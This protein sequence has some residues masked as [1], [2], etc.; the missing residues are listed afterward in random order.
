MMFEDV[1]LLLP[2]NRWQGGVLDRCCVYNAKVHRR[3]KRHSDTGKFI[4]RRPT[5]NCSRAFGRKGRL[6]NIR[7]GLSERENA[8]EGRK[9]NPFRNYV[10]SAALEIKAHTNPSGSATK[11]SV[12]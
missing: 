3:A 5:R 8:P 10:P 7:G 1:A 6:E 11:A 9:V 2:P 12:P 4:D